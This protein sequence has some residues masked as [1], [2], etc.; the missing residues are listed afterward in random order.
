MVTDD[1]FLVP[2]PHRHGT[3]GIEIIQCLPGRMRVRVP[4]IKNSPAFAQALAGSLRKIEGISECRANA[5]CASVTIWFDHRRLT[6]PRLARRLSRLSSGDIRRLAAG[7]GNSGRVTDVQSSSSWFEL[8]LSS[9]GVVLG[10]LCEPLAPVLV[11]LLLAGSAL[12]MLKRAYDAV[13]A[14]GRL[15]V[16][17]LDASATALLSVQGQFNMAAFMVWL[18]NLGDYI[19][20]ATVSQARAAVESVLAFQESFA[21]VVRGRRK[22]RISVS[23]IEVGDTVIAYPGDRIPIDGV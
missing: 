14:E 18:I 19:R 22:I 8:S 21:W 11:P 2:T 5:E 3:T 12:P 4:W 17:V 16:D 9:A 10:F 15:T 1:Q 20:D 6:A 23:K 13:A 7:N